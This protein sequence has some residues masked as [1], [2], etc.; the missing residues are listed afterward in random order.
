VP[1]VQ[2]PDDILLVAT[3]DH[4][5]P[6]GYRTAST[7]DSLFH[8][9]GWNLIELDYLTPEVRSTKDDL[10]FYIWYRGQDSVY[11]SDIELRVYE[12]KP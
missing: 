3:A 6:Y 10:S 11:V 4:K 5:G 7:P 1:G 2:K 9:N 8:P 12:R